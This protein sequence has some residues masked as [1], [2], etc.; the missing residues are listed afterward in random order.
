[1]RGEPTL[2]RNTDIR[3]RRSAVSGNIP[4]PAQLNF[5]ELALNTADGKAYMKRLENSVEVVVEIGGSI[6]PIIDNFA[7]NGVSANYT[8]SIVPSTKNVT[9]VYL[10]GVYQ[11]KDEYT[12]AGSTITLSDVP[13]SGTEVEIIT[14]RASSVLDLPDGIVNPD[15]LS[16]GSPAWD[17][18]GNVYIGDSL[19]GT[20][21]S[22]ISQSTAQSIITFNDD[23]FRSG[24]LIVQL[25]SA[26]S[27]YEALEALFIYDGSTVHINEYGNVRSATN[28][29]GALSATVAN[30]NIMIQYTRV[31][32][33]NIDAI[34]QYNL[35][36]VSAPTDLSSGSSTIDLDDSTGS[37]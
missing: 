18:D 4:T 27:Q 34:V 6:T 33:Q 5:G 16:T 12:L 24:K 13:D 23:T 35:I 3:L 1:L 37:I 2:A 28:T 32:I 20:I 36:G 29:L 25:I 22:T 7:A 30:G 26:D 17:E 15:T 10:N 9:S 11:N 14:L 19:Q 21:S 8:I 31:G